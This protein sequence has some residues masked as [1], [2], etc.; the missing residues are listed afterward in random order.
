MGKIENLK[1][2]SWALLF[3]SPLK[4]QTFTRC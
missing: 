4:T 2:V 1:A 3:V